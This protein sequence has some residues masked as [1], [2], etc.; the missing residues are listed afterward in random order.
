MAQIVVIY[1]AASMQIG[2]LPCQEV[3]GSQ[4]HRQ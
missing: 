1:N 2:A 4:D 3:R